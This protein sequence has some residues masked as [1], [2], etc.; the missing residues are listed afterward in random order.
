M[1]QYYIYYICCILDF[2]LIQ[3]LLTLAMI[4]NHIWWHFTS[5]K[6]SIIIRTQRLLASK[7]GN[8][9]G[10]LLPHERPDPKIEQKRI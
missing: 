7:G 9:P 3:L 2:F 10:I 4:K 8:G 6:F 5:V 1:Y